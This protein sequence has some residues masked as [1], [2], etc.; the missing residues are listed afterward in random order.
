MDI[1]LCNVCLDPKEVCY[2]RLINLSKRVPT[3]PIKEALIHHGHFNTSLAS[4]PDVVPIVKATPINPDRPKH[5]YIMKKRAK[6][7]PNVIALRLDNKLLDHLDL[8]AEESKKSISELVRSYLE[9]LYE[10][11]KED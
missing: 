8:L 5:K 9:A 6:N 10:I 7:Y 1:I 2:N 11:K 3:F 4:V